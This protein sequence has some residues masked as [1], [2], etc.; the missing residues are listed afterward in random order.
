MWRS[1]VTCLF[2]SLL[3]LSPKYVFSQYLLMSPKDRSPPFS[4]RQ[5]LGI[6]LEGKFSNVILKSPVYTW[7]EE[8]EAQRKEGPTNPITASTHLWLISKDCPGTL[9]AFLACIADG[10]RVSWRLSWRV[11]LPSFWLG[12][13]SALLSW[14]IG[15][16]ELSIFQDIF[17]KLAFCCWFSFPFCFYQVGAGTNAEMETDT[18]MERVL[19]FIHGNFRERDGIPM[20]SIDHLE[21]KKH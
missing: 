4:T 17:S 6:M 15:I 19:S 18:E 3:S 8:K 7:N 16:Y 14:V 9:S 1:E 5:C 13:N 20:C 11:V 10:F 2:F 12:L 21:T